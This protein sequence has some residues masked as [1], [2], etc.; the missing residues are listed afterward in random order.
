MV[1]AGGVGR[2]TGMTGQP[3]EQDGEAVPPGTAGEPAV[4]PY[5]PPPG[6]A[7]P[8]THAPP[9]SG[10]PVPHGPPPGYGY[11]YGPGWGVPAVPPAWPAGPGRP[12][13][14]TTAAVLGFV[15]G[16]LTVIGSLF[17]LAL[18]LGGERDGATTTLVLGLPCAAGMI[19]G[20][21][22]LLGRNPPT[23]LS[24]SACAA[25]VVLFL[26]LAV[27]AGT[28][29]TSDVE[30]VVAFLLVALPLPALTAVFSR[31]PATVGWASSRP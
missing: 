21:V 9:A 2:L 26:A 24:V 23:L 1:A 7:P 17:L 8:P 16:G 19:A 5:G 11:G 13:V 12:G 29:E 10:R 18:V 22:R 30:D 15:T 4:R 31:L 27:A 20:A 25:V 6:Y 3:Y 14:A 28:P